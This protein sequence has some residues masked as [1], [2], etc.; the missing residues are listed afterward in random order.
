MIS[1][2]IEVSGHDVSLSLRDAQV[3]I[4]REGQEIGRVPAED[5]GVL[6]VDTPSAQYTH[7]ALLA[8]LERGAVIVACDAKHMPAAVIAPLEG[9]H[10]QSERLR[11]QV[12]ASLPTRKRLWQKIVQAKIRHQ[13]ALHAG[14]ETRQ[15]LRNL[16]AKVKSG[17]PSNVEAQAARLHWSRWLPPEANFRRARG[18]DPPNNLLNY[19][20]MALRAAVARSLVGA[21]LHPS[22]ALR[23]Q[24]RYNAFGLAD[25]LMEPLRPLVDAKARELF[26]GGQAE[27]DRDTKAA[28]LALLT[29]TVRSG[30]ETGPLLIG[31]ERMAVSLARN[32]AGE[33]QQLLIPALPP[34]P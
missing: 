27:I 31:L 13:A 6:I 16:A 12:E 24:N 29:A 20:Y 25:D 28:L 22:L 23:H 30:T 19:G 11:A 18:G 4:T 3:T 26:L 17:D 10:L 9:H 32:L 34:D 8:L 15:R 14:E 33:E 2:T 1:R 7:R 21:G 5:V